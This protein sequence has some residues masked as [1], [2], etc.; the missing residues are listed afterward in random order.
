MK[1]LHVMILVVVA[2]MLLSAGMAMAGVSTTRHNLSS[3][4]SFSYRHAG[5]DEICVFC[6]TPHNANTAANGPLWNRTT[7]STGFTMYGTTQAGN[8]IGGTVSNITVLCFSCHDGTSALNVLYNYPGAATSLGASPDGANLGSS[9]ARLDK[10]LRNDHPVGIVYRLGSAA[11]G[12]NVIGTAASGQ[13][14]VKVTGAAA[15]NL[16]GDAASTVECSSCH[17][18]HGTGNASFLRATNAASALCLVCHIK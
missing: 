15:G 9:Y 18:P 5:T 6:H 17:D 7:D 3:G 10:D 12:L 4:G 2:I 14:V 11:A 8:F 16:S 1:K 13:P